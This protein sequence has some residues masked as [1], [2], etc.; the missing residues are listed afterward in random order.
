MG[1]LQNQSNKS[2]GS[3]Y[4]YVRN[5]LTRKDCGTNFY[6]RS[7]SDRL[8][9]HRIASHPVVYTAVEGDTCIDRHIII[10][11]IENHGSYKPFTTSA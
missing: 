2:R 3:P 10:I 11:A 9:R 8:I 5:L 1:C 7:S 4:D 6:D